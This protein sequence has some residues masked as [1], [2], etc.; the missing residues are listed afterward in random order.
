MIP[1]NNYV[2]HYD[3]TKAHHR[4]WLQAVLDRL[5][6]LEPGALQD[7]SELRDLWKAAVETKAPE[8][9]RGMNVFDG[10]M[11]LLDLIAKGEGSYISINCGRAGDTPGGR[12]GLDR[13]T[14]DQ[15]MALQREGV[16]AV[17]RYQFIPETLKI[18]ARDSGMKGSDL[19]D[20]EGQD[21][22]ATALLLG[23]KRPLL[24]DY[25]LGKD[26]PI[27]TAQLELAKEWASIPMA[28][29]KGFYDGDRAGNRA[30]AKVEDVKRALRKAREALAGKTLPQ[31]RLPAQQPVRPVKLPAHLTLRRT[32]QVDARG[33][34][35]LSLKKIVDSIP[36]AELLVVSG[37][38]GKQSFR[39]GSRSQ[40]GSREP[41]P[42]GRYSVGRVEWASGK[43]GDYSKSWPD[44]GLGPVWVS[45]TYSAPGVTDRSALG[46]HVD[47]NAPVAPGSVG[48]VVFRSMA[49]LRTFVGWMNQHNPK[50]LYVNW[51]LGTCPEVRAI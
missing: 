24:R 13:M 45:I 11:P 25:L 27:E 29:G 47:A 4:A 16:F 48:C 22:L 39:I 49:D 51:G 26:V 31:L 23:G 32:K 6:K 21:M 38:V 30:S 19:F 33:L 44:P 50:E 35:L 14:I 42:E 5:E 34:E 17:G 18:A 36:M 9:P 7:G 41:L 2:R 46:F 43:A 15:V 10:L 8:T 20:P 40:A 28:N 37:A 12:L 1:T 3:P